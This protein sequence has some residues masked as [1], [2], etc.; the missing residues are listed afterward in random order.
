[1]LRKS[2]PYVQQMQDTECGLCC[3]SMILKYY[4]S[5]TSIAYLKN[6]FEIGRDG[7]SVKEIG[8]ILTQFDFKVDYY[9]SNVEGLRRLADSPLI[10]FW[11]NVHFVV[12]EKIV[13]DQYHIVD[14]KIGKLVIGKE[15]FA[16]HYSNFVI[17]PTAPEKIVK[18]TAN[19]KEV[20][21][22]HS[23]FSKNKPKVA[24]LL[25]LSLLAYLVALSAPAIL[26]RVIDDLVDGKTNL[27]DEYLKMVFLIMILYAG[28]S[29]I[30]SIGT[31]SFSKLMDEYT[32]KSV[33]D[34]LFSVPFSFFLTRNSSD[35]LYRLSLLK[36]N[37][38]YLI[39]KLISSVFNII[40]LL[41]LLAIMISMDIKIFLI[42]VLASILTCI[43]LYPLQK[44]MMVL[45]RKSISSE[46]KLQA[47]EYETL[48]SMYAIK[49]IGLSDFF[50]SKIFSIYDGSIK[51]FENKSKAE[52]VYSIISS[53][54]VMFMPLIIILL[55]TIS[56]VS[57]SVG[58]IFFLNTI[59]IYFFQSLGDILDSVISLNQFK[60]N[61]ERIQDILL[62]KSKEENKDG[63]KI[64]RIESIDFKNVYYKYPGQKEYTLK[65]VSF[66][67]NKS[68]KIGLVGKTGSGKTTLLSLLMG[69]IEP[70]EGEILING[71]NIAD[72]N[73]E[74]FRK[75]IGYVPQES[76]I[77]SASVKDNVL[78]ERKVDDSLFYKAI[79]LSELAEDIY[80]LPM[81][82]NT[83]V[84]EGGRNLSGGQRQRIGIARAILEEPDLIV[85]DEA[86]SSIDNYT[87][88]R[89][90]DAI[91]EMKCSQLLVSHRLSTVKACDRILVMDKGEIAEEGDNQELLEKRGIYYSL[92]TGEM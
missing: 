65:D 63:I 61:N 82:E 14:P 72:I 92:Y 74:T 5:N 10:L 40:N 77:V 50:K 71:H 67:L 44:K 80:K 25:L 51:S 81:K 70:S 87:Q 12:L 56:K 17:K 76:F 3:V 54:V 4:G 90:S 31:I 89:I 49:S 79:G 35:L 13:K 16:E 32:Y 66:S 18:N 47:K 37:R 88:H 19:D 58:T 15:D 6:N 64:D 85:F 62:S 1:M 60:L 27:S 29:F 84:S 11:D 26:Q 46:S 43:I 33:I 55:I 59:L 28:V 69:I 30:K 86:T 68:E 78:M 42:V 39:D 7:M 38:N 22:Y 34:K 53:M 41:I 24:L 23:F 8:D 9:K 2:V 45:T 83:L 91:S 21:I 52:S 57:I 73:I 48:T 75:K 20:G 36:S